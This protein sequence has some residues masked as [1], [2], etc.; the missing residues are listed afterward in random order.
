M[1]F[2]QG[3]TS[4]EG[5]SIKRFIGVAACNVLGV[6]PNKAALEKIYGTTLEKEPEYIGEVEINGKKIKQVRIDFIVK[7]DSEK[8][9]D[10]SNKPVDFTSK[11]AIFVRNSYR[12]NKDNTKVQVIDKYGRTAWVTIEQ[13]KTNEIPVY[14]NGPANIDKD[15]RPAY[16]GEEELV[17]F[18][19]TYLGIPSV[20]K[21]ADGKIVGKIDNPEDAE[22]RLDNISKY[23][24]GDFSELSTIINYQPNNKIK[25]LF[26]VRNT[27]DGKTYQST[28]TRM[29]LKSFA[30]DYSRLEKDV[31][32]AQESGALS[33]TEFEFTDLHEYT[34]K[35]T[36]FTTPS[37]NNADAL[38]W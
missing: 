2:G 6:N 8:Y 36:D 31:K 33:T 16:I 19:K 18:I 11:V 3:Q 27:E 17:N 23:F 32:Q 24:D 21:W 30:S 10:S 7:P 1:A 20:D 38:P 12:Y 14:S 4:N 28:Y 9:L 34:V 37:G 13:A 35:T 22:A 15:Y 25:I 5:V 29:F 26:G